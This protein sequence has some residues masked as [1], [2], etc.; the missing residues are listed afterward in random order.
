MCSRSTTDGRKSSWAWI[1]AKQQQFQAH[2]LWLLVWGHYPLRSSWSTHYKL[3]LTHA[4][5]D[6]PGGMEC[7][8]TSIKQKG[9]R[10]KLME[11]NTKHTRL[12]S[13]SLKIYCSFQ[14]SFAIPKM[15][16]ILRTA[17]VSCLLN[18]RCLMISFAP[19][20]VNVSMT[21]ELARLQ[22]SLPMKVGGIGIRRTVTG[23]ICLFGF[24]GGIFRADPQDPPSLPPQY[25]WSACRDGT[26]LLEWAS[27]ISSNNHSWVT[28]SGFNQNWGLL[29][30]SLGGGTESQ[31]CLLTDTYPES[32]A[33]M[34]ECI[35]NFFCRTNRMDPQVVQVLVGPYVR[36]VT[37]LQFWGQCILRTFSEYFGGLL[38]WL[39]I[40]NCFHLYC[41]LLS[42]SYFVVFIYHNRCVISWVTG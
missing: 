17:H 31:A 14:H 21:F 36:G 10:F 40:Y 41:C 8:W 25:Q 13:C 23:T 1:R 5:R 11:K 30:E 26:C 2:L 35:P 15:S 18:L 39:F 28:P 6:S 33:C 38:C 29:L 12:I 37:Q 42:S 20:S 4:S 34:A 24:C 3:W 32:S 19:S 7:I 16:Y 9:D 27:P 22:V